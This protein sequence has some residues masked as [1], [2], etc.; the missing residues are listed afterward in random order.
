MRGAWKPCR[1]QERHIHKVP[2]NNFFR[3]SSIIS[4]LFIL[5]ALVTCSECRAIAFSTNL[6]QLLPVSPHSAQRPVSIECQLEG[7]VVSRAPHT[8][9]QKDLARAFKAAR[10]A[11]LENPI[12]KIDRRNGDLYVWNDILEVETRD[13]DGVA[14]DN[15]DDTWSK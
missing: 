6:P 13:V 2:E 3:N 4:M 8:F 5:I 9:K 15:D 11:G 12:V 7:N 1:I 10:A 14:P